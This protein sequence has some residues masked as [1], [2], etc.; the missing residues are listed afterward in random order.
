MVEIK[1]MYANTTNVLNI[2]KNEILILKEDNTSMKAII[3]GKQKQNKRILETI[4][5][6]T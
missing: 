2:L 5:T 6:T 1:N 4:W 3:N